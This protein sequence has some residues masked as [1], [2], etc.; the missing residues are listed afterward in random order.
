MSL[1]SGTLPGSGRAACECGLPLSNLPEDRIRSN[2]AI[3]HLLYSAVRVDARQTG[4]FQF[5]PSGNAQLLRA[6]WIFA[7]IPE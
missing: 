3:P 7:D 2:V 5:L 1:W 6:V 4:W